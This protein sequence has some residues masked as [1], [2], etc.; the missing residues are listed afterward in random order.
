[1]RAMVWNAPPL[2]LQVAGS[3]HELLTVRAEGDRYNLL[4]EA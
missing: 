2:R 1:M 4:G 3:C